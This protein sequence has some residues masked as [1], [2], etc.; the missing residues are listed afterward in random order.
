MSKKFFVMLVITLFM[1]GSMISFAGQWQNE[2]PRRAQVNKRL[3]NQNK[4][5]NQEVK[6][7]EINKGEAK[8]LRREDKNIRQ[9][10]RSMAK[11][12]GG[13]ITKE[14]Q[15]VLNQQENQNSREIGK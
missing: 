6:E 4:R 1:S 7:G 3:N 13:H 2:H 15:K 9:E 5:I 12:H 10:E 14:E 8:K 11:Q